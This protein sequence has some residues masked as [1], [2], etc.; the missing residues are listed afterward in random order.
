MPKSEK[1]I[2]PQKPEIVKK[3]PIDHVAIIMDG[4]RR[5]ADKKHLPRLAGH[6]SG[7]QT[8]KNLVKYVGENGLPYL[9][10][11]A[12]SSEN[13]NRSQEE[14]DY[15]LDLFARVVTDELDELAA[16]HVR[17]RFIGDLENMPG[18]LQTSFKR[19]MERTKEN[20]VL[21]LQVA[22]NY[23][24]RLEITQAA[25]KM[26]TDAL[27]GKIK[28]NEISE[29]LLNSYL[30]TSEL[31]DPDMIIRT[32]GEMRL[33]NYLLWQAAYSELYVTP[34]L[35]PDFSPADFDAAI[36]EFAQR[37]RRYGGD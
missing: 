37:N 16:N 32:G 2:S 8:L 3:W 22:I 6:K 28:P 13:W 14:V 10:V 7:V 23:G 31:P 9:T 20:T 15:L 12:F 34:V 1:V 26:A 19:A 35:W 27:S 33:S 29:A 5:W 11:Y 36:A 21:N 17:L 24:S 18:N 4:N 30:Y 25:Q